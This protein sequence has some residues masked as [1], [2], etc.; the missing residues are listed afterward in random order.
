MLR[1]SL[2][3]AFAATIFALSACSP[4]AAP[5]SLRDLPLDLTEQ[6]AVVAVV[7]SESAQ[8]GEALQVEFTNTVAEP[9]WFNPCV[10]EV[11]RA[12][13][14]GW[15][16]LPPELRLCN[17]MAYAIAAGGERVEPVDVPTFAS[18]GTYRFVIP[19]HNVG[20]ADVAHRA[21]STAFEV[22]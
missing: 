9:F 19:M 10:R 5:T 22:R 8:P 14:D 1:R 17:D 12:T 6:G 11:Q 16:T 13:A 18:P 7:A 20:S 15:E 2:R 3:L 4:E 21:V